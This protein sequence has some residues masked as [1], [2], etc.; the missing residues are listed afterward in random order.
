MDRGSALRRSGISPALQD[1]LTGAGKD[2]ESFVPRHETKDGKNKPYGTQS[3]S[4]PRET[5]RVQQ[6][7]LFSQRGLRY[8]IAICRGGENLRPVTTAQDYRTSKL[9]ART[10]STL[11]KSDRQA[12]IPQQNEQQSALDADLKRSSV[13]EDVQ[14]R[15]QQQ[16]VVQPAKDIWLD[17]PAPMSYRSTYRFSG[18]LL[19]YYL[20]ILYICS[21][22]MNHIGLA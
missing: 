10:L 2:R 5:H 18:E 20:Y 16:Q 21:Y 7:G 12:F 15:R 13:L 8:R 17:L 9:A 4:R 6:I 22:H 11:V 1:C 19:V 3:R 14:H